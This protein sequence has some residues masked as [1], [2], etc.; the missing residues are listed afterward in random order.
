MSFKQNL[1]EYRISPKY[2]PGANSKNRPLGP[3]I[4]NCFSNFWT[5]YK[6]FGKFDT[7]KLSF[8]SN[9]PFQVVLDPTAWAL[10]WDG[11]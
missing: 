3:K 9:V 1:I 8:G 6:F 2:R 4:Q 5:K 11:R 10:K 7:F